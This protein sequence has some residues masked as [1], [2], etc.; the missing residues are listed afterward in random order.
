MKK[1]EEE[2]FSKLVLPLHGDDR[3]DPV[4]K[5]PILNKYQ[6]FKTFPGT[7]GGKV[8]RDKLV[9]YI[10]Y[11][12]SVKSPL[13]RI[14]KDDLQTRKEEA[15]RLAGFNAQKMK[16]A[17]RR[18]LEE[19]VFRLRDDDVLKMIIRFLIVQNNRLWS[20]IVSFEESFYENLYMIMDPLSKSDERQKDTYQTANLKPKLRND[21]EEI[22]EKLENLY[23]ELF[24]EAEDVQEE[25]DNRE[26]IKAHFFSPE[27]VASKLEQK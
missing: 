10:N 21:N 9:R 6:E 20:M 18:Q 13:V 25:F 3:T 14:Y 2:D 16:K 8:N 12:Y 17:D 24:K 5:F 22:R 27:T 19:D 23:E 15:A 11:L 7:P 4:Q 1:I 26:E